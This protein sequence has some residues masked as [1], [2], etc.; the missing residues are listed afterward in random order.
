MAPV[1]SVLAALWCVVS[2]TCAG[3]VALARGD[4]EGGTPVGGTGGG[5]R[6]AR[7]GAGMV[8]PAF[9]MPPCPRHAPRPPF[10]VAPSLQVTV[11]AAPSASGAL[12]AAL[13]LATPP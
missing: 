9:A 6:D 11:V 8:S 5:V 12:S 3:G 13:A 7:G 4:S 1:G 2:A 10:E